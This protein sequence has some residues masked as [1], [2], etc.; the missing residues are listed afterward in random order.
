MERPHLL[1]WRWTSPSV[2]ELIPNSP[3]FGS[4]IRSQRYCRTSTR[5]FTSKGSY[6]PRPHPREKALSY[7]VGGAVLLVVNLFVI[8]YFLT[9]RAR[10]SAEARTKTMQLRSMKLLLANAPLWQERE[11]RLIGAQPRLENE[12][13]AGVQFLTEIKEAAKREQVTI[14]QPVI[15]PVEQRPA[16]TAVS[17]ELETKSTWAALIDFLKPLQGPEQFIVVETGTLRVDS[18]DP[19]MM[20]AHLK[21]AKWYAPK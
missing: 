17:V 16:C 15:L 4:K 11:A 1:H 8:N 20:R 5:S 12:A 2:C 19:T 21:I 13:T 14:E 7:F 9:N 18:G 10:L 3:P 6:E